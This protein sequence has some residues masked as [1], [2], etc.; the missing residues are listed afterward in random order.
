[1]ALDSVTVETGFKL[2]SIKAKLGYRPWRRNHR[3]LS[4]FRQP[5]DILIRRAT[6]YFLPS[7]PGKTLSNKSDLCCP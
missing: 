7:E 3:E 6:Q 2:S 1:M 5:D 4:S